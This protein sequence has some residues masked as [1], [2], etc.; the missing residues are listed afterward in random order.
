MDLRDRLAGADTTAM[1]AL[2]ASIDRR[3]ESGTDV[4][5]MWEN[6]EIRVANAALSWKDV[7]TEN[8]L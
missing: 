6:T 4:V 1:H 3:V 2:N 8:L 7:I 5:T